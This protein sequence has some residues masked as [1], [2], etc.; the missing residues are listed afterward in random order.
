MKYLKTDIV[1]TVFEMRYDC[2]TDEQIRKHFRRLWKMNVIDVDD[3]I[4]SDN[5]IDNETEPYYLDVDTNEILT[6]TDL[7]IFERYYKKYY[8]DDGGFSLQQVYDKMT[9]A[10]YSRDP[11]DSEEYEDVENYI[12]CMDVMNGGSLK[13]I[14]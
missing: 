1:K 5:V 11:E 10:E 2:H 9:T 12:Q 8:L 7:A 6:E 14:V 13:R 3:V 4:F